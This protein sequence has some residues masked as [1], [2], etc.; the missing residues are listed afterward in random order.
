MNLLNQDAIVIKTGLDDVKTSNPARI[1][2][3]NNS[4]EELRDVKTSNLH[5]TDM[6]DNWKDYCIAVFSETYNQLLHSKSLS[7]I[8]KAFK[9]AVKEI[10][11][12]D[13]VI[14]VLLF[15]IFK[16]AKDDKKYLSDRGYDSISDF[17]IDLKG[18]GIN[19]RTSFYNYVKIGKVLLQSV[20]FSSFTIVDS[21]IEITY[22]ELFSNFS[23]IK[24]LWRLEKITKMRWREEPFTFAEIKEHFLHDTCREFEVYM[25]DVWSMINELDINRARKIAA[26]QKKAIKG[27]PGNKTSQSVQLMNDNFEEIYREV[28]MGHFVKLVP[29]IDQKFIEN[30]RSYIDYRLK[31]QS[32]E[33]NGSM[34]NRLKSD[35]KKIFCEKLEQLGNL[36][37]DSINTNFFSEDPAL[38]FSPNMIKNIIRD[39]FKKKTDYELAEAFLINRLHTEPDLKNFLVS[40][41]VSA[42]RDFAYNV[43]D[44]G[45]SQ[46]K[47]LKKIGANLK[48]IDFFQGK[49]DLTVPGFLEKLYFLDRAIKNHKND[50]PLI[51]R[52]LNLLSAKRFREFA[53]NPLYRPDNEAINRHDYNI[54]LLLYQE[55]KSL[56]KEHESVTVI[57][58]P[59]QK[60]VDFFEKIMAT[61]T[62]DKENFER[63]YP[64]IPWPHLNEHEAKIA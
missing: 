18:S 31:K 64:E 3:N 9:Y 51:A 2:V 14:A 29:D 56:L 44:I 39:N 36:N 45:E 62:T 63:Q 22:D 7:D 35:W 34:E 46:Y 13:F 33:L 5:P 26:K 38:A 15:Q 10:G 37:A 48:Y 43:L 30:A 61:L 27:R 40:Y 8:E 21:R 50:Q 1:N 23:K 4:N 28:R 12:K 17:I 32:D 25:K 16:L 24:Y 55:N 11:N 57:G 42:I 58:F 20:S 41:G 60:H 19:D 6:S 53:R 47:R 54:A 59:S 49:V 52:Y